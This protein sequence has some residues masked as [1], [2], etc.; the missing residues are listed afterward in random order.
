MSV[1]TTNGIFYP[2]KKVLDSVFPNG[3]FDQLVDAFSHF[4]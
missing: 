2:N 4:A 1:L 3:D